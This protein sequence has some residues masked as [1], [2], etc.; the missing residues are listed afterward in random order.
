MAINVIQHGMGSIGQRI[1]ELSL[2]K[3]FNL[4][5]AIDVAE[6]RIGKDVGEIIGLKKKIGVEVSNDVQS[7]LKKVKADVVSNA[8]ISYVKPVYEQIKPFIKAGLNVVSICEELAYP[9]HK[10]PELSE[11]IDKNAKAQNVTVVATGFNPGF[12]MDLLPAI[13]ATGCWNIDKLKVQRVADL[14]V[15]SPIRQ[16]KRWGKKPLEF[17]KG[18]I[19]GSISM[20]I[21]L[22]ESTTMIADK[23]GW[24]LENITEW[25]E[26][27]FSKSVRKFGSITVNPGE[28][29]GI[30]QRL[31]GTEKGEVKVEMSMYFMFRPLP[32]EDG[33]EAGTKVW[34]EGEPNIMVEMK[35]TTA[36]GHLV[37][38]ARLVNIIPAVIEAKSGLLSVLDLPTTPPL[39]DK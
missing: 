24:K 19:N 30:I 31:V 32:E 1:V 33:V 35:G 5:A 6:D 18:I 12:A 13:A 14:S 9:W 11:E 36:M 20:H 4:V 7:V 37:S 25:W 15:H 2:R 3:G 10:Y 38:S 21:G 26:P 39:P 22:Y 27:M 34:I 28:S 17:R 16:G 8:T 29:T 23:L